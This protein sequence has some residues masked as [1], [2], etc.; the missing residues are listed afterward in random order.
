MFATLRN[1]NFALLWFAGLISMTGDW[2][3]F[4][5][6]P[7]YVYQLTQSTLATSI[8][9]IAGTIP[10]LIFG[11]LSGV[12]VDRWD[13]KRTMVIANLLMGIA[14]LPLFFVHSVDSVWIAYL[15][16]FFQSS[17]SQFFGPAEGALLPTLVGEEHL[18]PANAL[19]ALNNNLAR[20]VGPAIGGLVAAKW[21]ISGVM[22]V[23]VISFWLAAV[24]IAA[25]QTPPRIRNVETNAAETS[26][27]LPA[28][29]IKFWREW[30]EG[31][32]IIRGERR[33]SLIFMIAALPLL[34]EGVFG[35]MIVVFVSKVLGGG[36]MELGYLMSA[37]AIG[38]LIGSLVI[39]RVSRGI[40]L[41]RLMGISA[42]LFGLLDL[43]L[44]NYPTF[45][46]GFLLGY[47]LI[48]LVGV[49][50]VGYGT[51]LSAMLQTTVPDQYRGRVLGAFGTTAAFLYL[52][53]T[54][55]AGHFGEYLNVV[56]ILNIQGLGYVLT[57]IL[58]LTLLSRA[59]QSDVVSTQ[60]AVDAPT[61]T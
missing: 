46:S 1:R 31:L 7:I 33:I 6:L 58:A 32:N 2:V 9:F 61:P 55:I 25:I 22:L 3:M 50:A 17:I 48:G 45:V 59:Y 26:T 49:P 57:G 54:L 20:L 35:I 15:V 29:F 52:I 14:L 18:V 37:Q 42:I 60:G 34:G 53:G 41:Y 8:M 27:S 51:G 5:G 56:T 10:R 38:G 47:L 24:L 36:E 12:F 43:A 40:P 11:S 23:D 28:L 44:F 4:I 16:F 39:T 21:S 30:L 19:N 13:R